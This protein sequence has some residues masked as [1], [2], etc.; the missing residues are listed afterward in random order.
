MRLA[1]KVRRLERFAAGGSVCAA[2]GLPRLGWPVGAR[3]VVDGP[4]VVAHIGDV[5]SVS[6]PARPP[7][8]ACGRASVFVISP[9]DSARA[10][11][12]AA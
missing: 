10:S 12:E 2:C 11:T 8:S 7:C 1:T 4:A 6:A 9:P 3:L 5:P